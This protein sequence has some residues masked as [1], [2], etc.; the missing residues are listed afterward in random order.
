MRVRPYEAV[1]VLRPTL[2][3]DGITA[4]LDRVR[5]AVAAGGGTVR[6]VERWGRRRLAYEIQDCR[7]AHY[8]LL[9]FSAPPAGG[10]AELEHLCRISDDVLRHLVVREQEGA[11]AAPKEQAEST[12][13]PAERPAA[14]GA[15][16]GAAGR[17][18]AG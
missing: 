15:V 8:V 6:A 3:E 11:T 4:L 17:G 5:Q 14:A 12:A 9:R 13:G 18:G 1:L 10:T 2:D 7:E 16:A